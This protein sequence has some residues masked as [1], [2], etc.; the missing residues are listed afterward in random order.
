MSLSRRDLLMAAPLAAAAT[1][2]TATAAPGPPA[3]KPVRPSVICLFSKHL[4]TLPAK[5][6]AQAV[7]SLGFTGIDL[8]VR[9]D[10][11]VKPATVEKDLPPFIEAIRA[12][13]LSVPLVTTVLLSADDPTARPILATSGKLGVPL[14]K[15]GYYKYEYKDVRQ[16]L[17]QAGAQ[18]KGLAALSKQHKVQLGFHNHGDCLGG[19]IWDAVSIVDPLDPKWAGYYLDTRHVFAEG[20]QSAWKVATHLVGP[21]VKAVSVKDFHWRKGASGWEIAK[22]PLGEGHGR[23][24]RRAGHP[25]PPQLQRPALPAPRIQDRRRPR[26]RPQSRRPRPRLPQEAA[27]YG[28]R[29]RLNH[30]PLGRQDNATGDHPRWQEPHL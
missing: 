8:T 21:R 7:K 19:P 14:F 29:R 1:S 30:V 4:P 20:G 24:G 6:L 3:S 26:R 5:P 10:G 23:R 27:R 25:G 16:E 12:E 13:G 9:P 2:S 11:H 22:V 28:V 15:P 17:R 18:L